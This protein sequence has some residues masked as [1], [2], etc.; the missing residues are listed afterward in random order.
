MFTQTAGKKCFEFELWENY[1]IYII[2]LLEYYEK[3]TFLA[4]RHVIML[5]PQK[6]IQS[7]ALTQS[8]MF[9]NFLNLLVEKTF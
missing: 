1:I 8:C 2:I 9:E 7:E 3:L 4:L 5:F 6:F